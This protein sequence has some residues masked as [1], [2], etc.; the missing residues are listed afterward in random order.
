MFKA[1]PNLSIYVKSKKILYKFVRICTEE[2]ENKLNKKCH[3][4][5]MNLPQIPQSCIFCIISFLN[6]FTLCLNSSGTF[7][8]LSEIVL[9]MLALNIK[10]VQSTPTPQKIL[11]D[12]RCSNSKSR[13]EKRK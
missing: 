1:A 8:K 2:K 13:R 4:G 12:G 3:N 10:F 9:Q 11:N 7:S 6:I 5:T